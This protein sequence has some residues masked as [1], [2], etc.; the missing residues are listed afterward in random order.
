[1]SQPRLPAGPNR[2]TP[3]LSAALADASD[4]QRAGAPYDMLR[5]EVLAVGP[6][7]IVGAT[8]T[9]TLGPATPWTIP[10][11]HDLAQLRTPSLRHPPNRAAVAD[12]VATPPS[13]PRLP[14]VLPWNLSASRP[15]GSLCS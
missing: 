11:A 12:D 7:F 6:A 15:Y 2:C 10:R 3:L 9:I 8:F 1:M 14:M 13:S 4:L 5:S